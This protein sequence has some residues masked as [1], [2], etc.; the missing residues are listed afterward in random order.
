VDFQEAFDSF[1][2]IL[3]VDDE[4]NVRLNLRMTLETEGYEI[5]ESC[6]GAHALQALAEHSFALAI[7]DL[8]MPD[9]DG[10]A[11]LARMR[12]NGI[13]VP[14]VMISASSEVQHAVHAMKLGAVDFLQKPLRPETLRAV[15]SENLKRHAQQEGQTAEV[16]ASHLFAA[17]RC[18]K[19]RAFAMARIHLVKALELDANSAAAFNLAGVLSELLKDHEKAK[20]C[21]AF[22]IKVDK[23]YEPARQ[24]MRRLRDM[25][26]FGSSGEPVDLGRH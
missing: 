11:L 5:Y 10:L 2:R 6:S 1:R 3:I 23:H 20:K 17:R 21:Y 14:A 18:L 26:L 9:M 8:R 7:L 24:N 22:A 13:R 25:E 4:T 12:E 19:Q 15:V 16:F